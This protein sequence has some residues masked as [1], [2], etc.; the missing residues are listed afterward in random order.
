MVERNI[1]TQ[2]GK[3]CRKISNMTLRLVR[4]ISHMNCVFIDE[5]KLKEL[6]ELYKNREFYIKQLSMTTNSEDKSLLNIYQGFL[7]HYDKEIEAFGANERI[8]KYA[9]KVGR[10]KANELVIKQEEDL[11]QYE[12]ARIS[13][14]IM[15]LCQDDIKKLL[16]SG[17]TPL[18]QEVIDKHTKIV[19][20]QASKGLIDFQHIV[21]K[22]EDIVLFKTN[23]DWLIK[24]CYVMDEKKVKVLQ[25]KG[26]E[27]DNISINKRTLGSEGFAAGS[28]NN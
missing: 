6:I 13:N 16:N 9:H 23:R 15:C 3:I 17:K 25:V 11:K 2:K 7:K 21:L 24:E 27:E 10:K 12:Q 4:N 14:K 5:K 22:T 8:A 18:L 26:I 1:R 28:L 20:D 19:R